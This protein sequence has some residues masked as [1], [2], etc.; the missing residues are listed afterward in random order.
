[1][2]FIAADP[3][4]HR[5]WHARHQ[6]IAEYPRMGTIDGFELTHFGV[7][8]AI[9]PQNCGPQEVSCRV[10][11]NG[12]VHLAA[13]TDGP[14]L[15]H[16]LPGRCTDEREGASHHNDGSI[17]A[18]SPMRSAAYVPPPTHNIVPLGSMNTAFIDPVPRSSPRYTNRSSAMT[19]GGMRV[20]LCGRHYC[21][22]RYG[23]AR[24]PTSP[25]TTECSPAIPLRMPHASNHGVMLLRVGE[26]ERVRR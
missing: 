14:H 2:W 16:Q 24:T 10:E 11:H 19:L 23:I 22:S 20:P 7:R 5:T 25:V 8:T 6:R 3:R 21:I 15:F 1:M 18:R 4:E 17:S 13:E 9:V 26:V 12:P